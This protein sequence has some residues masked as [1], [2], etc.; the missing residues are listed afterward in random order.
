LDGWVVRDIDP[1]I[2]I[3]KLVLDSLGIEEQDEHDQGDTR[4]IARQ[5]CLLSLG[6]GLRLRSGAGA[7]EWIVSF[8]PSSGI[9]EL[10]RLIDDQ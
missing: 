1:V 7:G 3:D 4:S 9:L 8:L 5:V 10:V 6:V 2:K